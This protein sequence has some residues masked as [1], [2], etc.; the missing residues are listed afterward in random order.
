MKGSVQI[1]AGAAVLQ[2]WRSW[3][4]ECAPAQAA[5]LVNVMPRSGYRAGFST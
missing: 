5:P 3:A 1:L 4:S 2:P